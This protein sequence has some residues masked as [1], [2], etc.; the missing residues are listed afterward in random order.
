MTSNSSATSTSVLST[1]TA[2]IDGGGSGGPNGGAPVPGATGG[3][4]QQVYGP[5][6]SYI[7]AVNA[8]RRNVFVVG[9]VGCLVGGGLVVF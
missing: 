7:S 6:D 4:G 9:F 1:A 2:S 5:P 3:G 8:L